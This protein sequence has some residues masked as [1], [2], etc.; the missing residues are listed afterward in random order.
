ME[1]SWPREG[2]IDT[3]RVAQDDFR[4][5]SDNMSSHLFKG[6]S[7]RQ[8]AKANVL[9]YLSS[10]SAAKPGGDGVKQTDIFRDCGF[11][12]DDQE[13]AKSTQ[14]Q[15]WVVA[16]LRELETE[17]LVDRSGP[18]GKIRLVLADF[19]SHSRERG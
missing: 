12:W 2:R 7:L 11:D 5:Y 18:R 13:S 4:R 9:E 17:G 3:E 8:L 6:Q 10:S 19:T 15:Y 16:L 14:Q 1:I